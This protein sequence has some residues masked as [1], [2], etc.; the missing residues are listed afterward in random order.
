MGYCPKV[1]RGDRPICKKACK[2]DS[3]CKEDEKCCDGCGRGSKKFCMT[4]GM[5]LK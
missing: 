5:F 3:E 2:M 4:M 1:E